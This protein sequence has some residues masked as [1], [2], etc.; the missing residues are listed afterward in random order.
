MEGL[1]VFSHHPGGA[2]AGAVALV[3]P[4]IHNTKG[5][6]QRQAFGAGWGG[7][8]GWVIRSERNAYYGGLSSVGAEPLGWAAF[9]TAIRAAVRGL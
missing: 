6:Q 7:K 8:G 9:T 3:T 2:V 5:L 1:A 4:T